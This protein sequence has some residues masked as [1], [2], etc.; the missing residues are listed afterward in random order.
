[1]V[2]VAEEYDVD[3][4]ELEAKPETTECFLTMFYD[5]M[6]AIDDA[7]AGPLGHLAMTYVQSGKAPDKFF[8][9]FGRTVRELS[10]T[11]LLALE[12]LIRECVSRMNSGQSAT[13][14]SEVVRTDS[15]DPTGK[16]LLAGG[17]H[18]GQWSRIQEMDNGLRLLTVMKQH[19]LAVE[20]TD[21]SATFGGNPQAIRIW[22]DEAERT[23]RH[24][25]HAR[26]IA[27]L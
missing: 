7:A 5:M 22:R 3:L 27:K 9:A 21:V 16:A 13:P 14:D 24:L 25:E 23:L 10:S 1:M 6:D 15:R 2:A 12:L 26:K 19:G 11:E 8:R 17:V 18:T 4:S 20:P